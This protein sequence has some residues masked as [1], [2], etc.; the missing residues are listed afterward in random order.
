MDLKYSTYI[1]QYPLFSACLLCFKIKS[2]GLEV[3]IKTWF[4]VSYIILCKMKI[5]HNI[6]CINIYLCS[7]LMYPIPTKTII[8]VIAGIW[9]SVGYLRHWLLCH[10]IP[11][12]SF[13]V[14]INT[15][16]T[17]YNIIIARNLMQLR[18][19]DYWI[20]MHFS[21]YVLTFFYN[22]YNISY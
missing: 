12:Y 18:S 7:V 2:R 13:A 4:K 3:L 16:Y 19:T 10:N 8:R 15:K 17:K 1:I 21:T 9:Y 6:Y 22:F 20:C 11:T 5:T 14:D